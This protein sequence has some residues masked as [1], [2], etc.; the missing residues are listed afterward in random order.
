MKALIDEAPFFAQ[1]AQEKGL[2]D[3]VAYEDELKLPVGELRNR[4]QR[5]FEW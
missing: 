4:D 2:I 3:D 5:G 1:T